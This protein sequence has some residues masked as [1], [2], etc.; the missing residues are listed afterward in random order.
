MA[1]LKSSREALILEAASQRNALRVLMPRFHTPLDAID[2]AS[3][4][5]ARVSRGGPWPVLAVIAVI[6]LVG[7]GRVARLMKSA[8]GPLALLRLAG[9]LMMPLLAAFLSRSARRRD[10]VPGAS[11]E[12]AGG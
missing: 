7:G 5:A 10:D 12:D 1:P 8:A 9:P 6:T 2:R 4:F 11:R 3:R